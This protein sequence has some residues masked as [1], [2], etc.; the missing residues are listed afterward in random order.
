MYIK[1]LEIIHQMCCPW[2]K[3]G[4]NKEEVLEKTGHTVGLDDVT[5]SIEEG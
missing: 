2:L 1:F 5:L 4:A 3:M